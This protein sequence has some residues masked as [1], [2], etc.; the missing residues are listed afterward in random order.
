MEMRK[1]SRFRNYVSLMALVIVIVLLTFHFIED[2]KISAVIAG[3]VFILSTGAIFIY[4]ALQPGFQKRASFWGT[5]AFL[6]LSA[7]P[8]FI[9]RLVYWNLSF[10]MIT[11]FGLTGPQLH[12][13]SNEV[14]ILMLICFFI[15]SYLENK[16]AS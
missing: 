6:F 16:K 4:E 13:I 11:F 3:V 12:T 10:E 2:R 14:F 7:L 1:R 8:I 9:L 5:G 15:D